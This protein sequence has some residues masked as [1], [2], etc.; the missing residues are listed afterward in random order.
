MHA[1]AR[2]L[3]F[4]LCAVLSTQAAWSQVQPFRQSPA[5]PATAARQMSREPQAPPAENYEAHAAHALELARANDGSLYSF[6][7]EMP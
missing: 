1:S 4:L 7:R 3:A 6:L 2:T 5:R